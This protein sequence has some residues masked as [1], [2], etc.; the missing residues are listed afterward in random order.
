MNS[1]IGDDPL[2]HA[3]QCLAQADFRLAHSALMIRPLGSSPL[4]QGDGSAS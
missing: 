3:G 2:R 4:Q 1:A